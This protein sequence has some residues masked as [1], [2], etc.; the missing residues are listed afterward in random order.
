MIIEFYGLPGAGKTTIA[1]KLEEKAGFKIIKIKSKKELIFFNIL[2]LFKHP[3]RFFILLYYVINNS[4]SLKEFYY[5]FM[6]AFLTNAKYQKAKKYKK[7][8]IDQGY[9]QGILS[10]FNKKITL[11]KLNKYLDVILKPEKLFIFNLSPEIMKL[12]TASRGYFGRESFGEDYF[13][14]WIETI[15][16]NDALIKK[17]ISSF[18]NFIS[19]DANKNIDEIYS[20]L[21]NKVKIMK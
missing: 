13:E 6:N 21:I 2:F 12:R 18:Q 7:A 17:E 3:I 8:I 1:Q 20:E 16:D 19:I 11:S 9:F 10:I 4:T 14:K 5:K 15:I